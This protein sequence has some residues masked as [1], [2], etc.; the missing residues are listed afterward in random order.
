MSGV[1]L[2]TPKQIIMSIIFYLLSLSLYFVNATILNATYPADSLLTVSESPYYVTQN[3][4]INPGITLNVENGVEIIFHGDF[5]VLCHN[6][7]L[8]IGCSTIPNGIDSSTDNSRG[9]SS[10]ATYSYIHSNTSN[11][12]RE[13]YIR[14]KGDDGVLTICNT[15]FEKLSYG[16]YLESSYMLTPILFDN[17]EFTDI[18]TIARG[19]SWGTTFHLFKDSWF[20]D[21]TNMLTD[22]GKFEFNN[23]LIESFDDFSSDYDINVHYSTIDGHGNNA[24]INNLY[25]TGPV[26]HSIIRN[27]THGII[28]GAGQF[29]NDEL[30][31]AIEYNLITDTYVGIKFM[32]VDTWQADGIEGISYNNFIGNTYNIEI[33]G[34]DNQ[35]YLGYN[36][37]GLDATNITKIASQVLDACDGH[38]TGLKTSSLVHFLYI[39]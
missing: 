39:F 23:C 19:S 5:R 31:Q 24:C 6:C 11:A 33:A 21:N 9:L 26:T 17:C 18:D 32:L 15:K 10:S 37:W 16:I 30:I 1:C 27:C 2:L 13:G 36:Y 25:S 20:H 28:T 29:Y 38:S 35:P 14:V 22:R 7:I 3:I 4:E 34:T 12:N 8:N